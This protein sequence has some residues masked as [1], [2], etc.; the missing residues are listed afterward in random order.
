MSLQSLLIKFLVL[1]IFAFSLNFEYGHYY[2]ASD[3]SMKMRESM[4]LGAGSSFKYLGIKI[5]IIKTA[6]K[7]N[8]SKDWL[9]HP[10]FSSVISTE[11]CNG[12]DMNSFT[13]RNNKKCTRF[14][15]PLT[16]PANLG[17]ALHL[18]EKI[19]G[20][21]HPYHPR[22]NS[23]HAL[24]AICNHGLLRGMDKLPEVVLRDSGY[25]HTNAVPF[26]IHMISDVSNINMHDRYDLLQGQLLIVSTGMVI[27]VSSGIVLTLL[28]SC[29]A[30]MRSVASTLL[31]F[32]HEVSLCNSRMV[33]NKP[34][35]KLL[36]YAREVE[37][38]IS[39]YPKSELKHIYF[40]SWLNYTRN[41]PVYYE[42]VFVLTQYDDNQI[43]QFVLE[44]L[45]KLVYYI[46]RYAYMLVYLIASI[47]YLL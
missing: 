20:V 15:D 37:E 28:N 11:L 14:V 43:G 41:S 19:T 26:I 24:K 3:T 12:I 45:P 42:K 25:I 6:L 9:T 10:N 8:I 34:F 23:H 39:A 13:K 4:S 7:V 30:E 17:R 38:E 33:S 5:S 40:E 32:K 31:E 21:F 1:V 47:Q 16:A 35:L 44:V 2:Y 22:C 46:G 36:E 27:S 29:S 18:E